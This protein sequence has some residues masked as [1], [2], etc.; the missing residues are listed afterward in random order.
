VNNGEVLAGPRM[1]FLTGSREADG[2]SSQTAGIYDLTADGGQMLLNAVNYMAVPEPSAAVLIV[3]GIV[4][5][6]MRRRVR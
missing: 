3:L 6:V 4:G 2:V 1:A 5:L